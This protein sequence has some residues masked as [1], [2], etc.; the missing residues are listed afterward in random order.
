MWGAK[1]KR[2]SSHCLLLFPFATFLLK[3]F[4]NA[5]GSGVSDTQAP[6]EKAGAH[7][8][9]REKSGEDIYG[10]GFEEAEGEGG[11]R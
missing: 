4:H 9:A 3:L 5:G 2:R 8:Q 1:A 6:E 10:C 11:V 7:A